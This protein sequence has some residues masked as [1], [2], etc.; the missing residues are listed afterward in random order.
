VKTGASQR[1]IACQLG[2]SQATVKWWLKKHDLKTE[3]AV[4]W[5]S[6]GHILMRQ[7][8]K[9]S[10]IAVCRRHGEV[11]FIR[12]RKG[13]YRCKKCDWI[14][15]YQRRV[16]NRETLLKEHGGKCEQCGF[17]HPAALEFHHLDR[18]Q[19]DF[20]IGVRAYRSLDNLRKEA[21]KCQLLCANCHR[22][23]E[24]DYNLSLQSLR[25]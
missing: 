25:A 22:I 7:G 4:S 3:L 20:A 17:S 9:R 14:E 6:D 12:K 11:T 13:H 1:E 23:V 10:V 21:E 15:N 19:K 24:Y 8:E 2:V 18:L 16:R 5:A